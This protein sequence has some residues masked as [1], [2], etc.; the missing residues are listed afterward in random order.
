MMADSYDA[1]VIGAGPNGLAAAIT[2]AQAG[3]SVVVLE[4][5]ETIGGGAR[6]AETTEPGFVHDLASAI[7]PLGMGSPFFSQLPLDQ[8]GLE[9]IVP[10]ASVAHPLNNGEA[11]IAWH[12]L[13]QTAV[14][15][16]EDAAAYRRTYQRLVENWDDVTDFTMTP[17]TRFPRH[18]V[19]MLRL[20]LAGFAPATQFARNRFSTEA[21]RALFA[22]HVA[23]S[24]LPLTYPFTSTFGLVLGASAHTVG[25]GFP[26]GGAQSLTNALASYL[27]SIGGEIRTGTRVRDLSDLPP[28]RAAIF[29]TT[30]FQVGQ[31]ARERLPQHSRL[32]MRRFKYGPAA[33]KVDFALS[34]P[35]PWA[36]PE[37]AHAATVHV[38]GTV[39][40]ITLSEKQMSSGVPPTKPF[41]LLAQHSLFDDTRAPEGKHTAWAYCHV[42]NASRFDMTKRIQHQIERYA[43]GFRDTIIAMRSW[44]PADLEASNANLIGGNV[45]GG[46]NRGSRVFFRPGIK[47]I[48]YRTGNPTIFIGSAS[49]SPGAGVHGM[50]GHHAARE[51]LATALR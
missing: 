37:V 32:W 50:S 10:V 36:N 13:H 17:L 14:G 9:W 35:I 3:R 6:S 28:H 22:G 42:P 18:P 51:A 1:V 27:K 44:S 11:A 39:K 25:W 24:L 4:A 29:S 8:H 33:F 30:P 38:G 20:G 45:G 43:P 12:D 46:S 41:V 21:A 23:H 5:N 2:V 16:G 26:K 40:E 31:I 48:P 7:H 15:L 47:I 19:L 34:E 49:T